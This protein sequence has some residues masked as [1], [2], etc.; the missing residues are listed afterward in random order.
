MTA[1]L[2]STLTQALSMLKEV[3]RAQ[4][5]Q[6]ILVPGGEAYL[7]T[8]YPAA[9]SLNRLVVT[10]PCSA[11]ELADAADDVLGAAGLGHRLIEVLDPALDES[12]APG[13]QKLGYQ[14]NPVVVMVANQIPERQPIPVEVV[15][16]SLQER[17]EVVRSEWKLEQPEWSDDVIDQLAH[18]IETMLDVSQVTSLG[19]R[20]PDGRVT[21]RADLYQRDGAAQIEEVMTH[22][23]FRRQGLATTIVLHAVERARADG[24][25]LIFLLADAEDWPRHL[26]RRLGFTEVGRIVSYQ[27]FS[28]SA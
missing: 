19:T 16:L 18:R 5:T 15:E 11:P 24:D 27:R 10:R 9:H 4:S 7:H 8:G 21:S 23:D 25:E 14:R 22:P 17:I 6:V 28:S 13:L 3:S 2:S 20:G 26:Y 1:T 12:L